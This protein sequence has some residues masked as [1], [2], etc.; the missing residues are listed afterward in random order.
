MQERGL[1]VQ[2]RIKVLLRKSWIKR[3]V[4]PGSEEDEK[5][6]VW[7]RWSREEPSGFNTNKKVV[8]KQWGSQME[9]KPSTEGSSKLAIKK[10]GGKNGESERTPNSWDQRPNRPGNRIRKP[11]PPNIGRETW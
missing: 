8:E 4:L 2:S 7:A 5:L 6:R 11:Q 3:G 1:E 9:V 10:G